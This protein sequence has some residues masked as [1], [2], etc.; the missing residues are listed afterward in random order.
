MFYSYV[1]STLGSILSRREPFF[2][3]KLI[4]PSM[5]VNFSGKLKLNSPWGVHI[6][7]FFFCDQPFW[8]DNL[9][10]RSNSLKKKT[11]PTT[12]LVPKLL[13]R[14]LTGTKFAKKFHDQLIWNS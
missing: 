12:V 1:K 10:D 4:Y 2:R 7:F 9:S 3:C 14:E 13:D 5:E 6:F 8:R 11:A